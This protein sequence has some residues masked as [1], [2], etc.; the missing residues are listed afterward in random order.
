M[1][2]ILFFFI[3]IIT[4]SFIACNEPQKINATRNGDSILIHRTII[5]FGYDNHDYIWFE[6]NVGSVATAGVVH[7]PNCHCYDSI[8]SK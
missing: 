5:E 3:L 6:S 8:K 4:S 2:K 1:K 7:S